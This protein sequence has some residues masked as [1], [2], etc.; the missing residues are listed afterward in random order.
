MLTVWPDVGGGPY[1]KR[2]AARVSQQVR[3]QASGLGRPDSE[4][5][6]IERQIC[7][8]GADDV[9]IL[10]RIYLGVRGISLSTYS[11]PQ[12]SSDHTFPTD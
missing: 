3:S 9:V 12:S 1:W 2:L 7:E 11:D 8:Q 10:E 4:D 6:K 5:I